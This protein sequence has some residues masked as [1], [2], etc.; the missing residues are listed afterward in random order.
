MLN[1]YSLQFFENERFE[2][3][4]ANVL[5]STLRFTLH[6]TLCEFPYILTELN[7]TSLRPVR[8]IVASW[9]DIDDIFSHCESLKCFG[10]RG[11]KFAIQKLWYCSLDI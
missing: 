4:S 3:V 1:D 5:K 7:E 10:Q 2:T 8:C 6:V 11:Y 9:N